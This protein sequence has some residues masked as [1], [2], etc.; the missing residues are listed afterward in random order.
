MWQLGIIA[1]YA[2]VA[3]CVIMLPVHVVERA[4]A[5]LPVC[6]STP[7]CLSVLVSAALRLPRRRCSDSAARHRRGGPS[8]VVR[9]LSSDATPPTRSPRTRPRPTDLRRAG[10]SDRDPLRALPGYSRFFLAFGGLA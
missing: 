8:R 2:V 5:M 6:A 1:I 10:P 9:C 4:T 7:S 3:V